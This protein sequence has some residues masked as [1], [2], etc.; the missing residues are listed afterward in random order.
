MPKIS[1]TAVACRGLN[2]LKQDTL[3][4]AGKGH[5]TYQTI[6]SE[7]LPFSDE[8]TVRGLIASMGDGA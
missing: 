6:G 2:R 4:I 8:A 3:L 7:T 5:E 1:A